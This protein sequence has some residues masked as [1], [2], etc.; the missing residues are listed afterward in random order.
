MQT[1][2]SLRRAILENASANLLR[3]AASGTVALLLPPFLVRM[4]P[5][6]TYST[7]ALVLQLTV[8]LGLLDFGIQTAVARFVAHADE[9]NDSE[10]RDGIVS[11]AFLLLTVASA[12][13]VLAVV[14]LAWQLPHVF[15]A[16]PVSLHRDARTALLLMG[17]SFALGLPVSVISAIFVG[18]QR[19]KVPVGIL[20]FNKL[21]TA[22]LT[23]AVV[24]RHSN[25]ATMGAAVGLA[26]V[27]SY[28]ASYMA[29]RAWAS[30][31]RIQF[32][33]ASRSCARQIA[34][35]SAALGVWYL[36]MM[37]IS[38]LDLTIVGVFDYVAVAYYAVAVTLTNFVVQTQNAIFA[39][40]L[41]A[42][43]V[44][45]ARGDSEKLGALLLCS[46]RYGMLVLLAMA[47]PLVLAGRFILSI[48]VGRDYALHTTLILQVL[49]VANVV[50]LSFLPYAT[51]LLGMGE[52]RKVVM[53][54]MAEGITN[55]LASVLGAWRFGAIGVAIGTLV[56]SFV[57]IGVHFLYH[58]PRTTGIVIDRPLLLKDGILRPLICAAPFGFLLFLRVVTPDLSAA[59]TWFLTFIAV[60]GTG[61]LLWNFGLIGSERTKIGSSFRIAT[62]SVTV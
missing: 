3:L 23:L 42:S 26:N 34:S 8:Y 32:K 57:S 9:L 22:A 62:R 2:Q 52:Q 40:V 11:T 7:W 35:Y 54:P 48:W 43:A 36:A 47:L 15:R 5:K 55:L 17:G 60:V 50:R 39:A 41:P 51:L 29:W 27:L 61:Y 59:S 31:V 45:N 33:L 18:Q 20:I 13:G 25:L 37:M 46:T 24:L 38:G 44:L 6:E 53:S 16:M 4:L 1:K 49:V 19:N 21:V 56:G 14:V 12:L 30:D 28:G 58:M 10:Q